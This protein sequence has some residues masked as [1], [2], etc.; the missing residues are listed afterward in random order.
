ME[1]PYPTDY[2]LLMAH[3]LW[4]THYQILLIIL[5]KEFIKLNLDQDT[6]IK[7]VKR[8]KLNTKVAT[9]FLNTQS[10]KMILLNKNVYSVTKITKKLKTKKKVQG[11]SFSY[12]QIF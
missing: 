5:L 9:A 12:I 4:H 8:A 7:N 3:N 1:K 10:L 6:I 11:I 2:N